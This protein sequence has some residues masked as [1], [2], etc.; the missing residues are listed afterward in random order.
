ME[1]L[2]VEPKKSRLSVIL[3]EEQQS[4]PVGEIESSD[5]GSS[6]QERIS[7]EEPKVH[8]EQR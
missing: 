4:N 6:S 5:D 8:V 2:D 7:F 3:E 1:W